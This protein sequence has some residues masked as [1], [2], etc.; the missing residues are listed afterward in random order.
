LRN[1]GQDEAMSKA[2][3]HPSLPPDLPERVFAARGWLSRVP[4]AVRGEL[5]AASEVRHVV[6]GEALV[7]AGEEGGGPFG[8]LQGRVGCW[9][10]S[11]HAGPLLG[12]VAVP[13]DWF[14][15][16]PVQLGV[17]RSVGFAALEPAI[18]LYLPAVKLRRMAADA[19]EL[20]RHLARLSETSAQMMVALMTDM[21]IPDAE[22]RLAA[23][24]VRTRRSAL[25]VEAW[26]TAPLPLGQA[27][28]AELCGL[29]RAHVNRM[30]RR[31]TDDGLVATG[32]N[33]IR[34]LAP[35]RL[36]AIAAG[37]PSLT[38]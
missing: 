12:H 2:P 25:D 6:A 35:A 23:V 18:V 9:G 19:P 4:D 14:G 15:Q 17:A 16:G 30:L 36:A 20:F 8:L 11:P 7:G 28:L 33:N 34:L 3:A 13:G 22:R 37:R 32:Y 10:T 24:L 5:L 27:A 29:S 1:L 26:A 31:W 21:L 38:G